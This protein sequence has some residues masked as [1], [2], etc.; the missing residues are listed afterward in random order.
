MSRKSPPKYRKRSSSLFAEY[1]KEAGFPDPR[2]ASPA[3]VRAV[4]RRTI[5]KEDPLTKRSL[6]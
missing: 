1:S 4:L 2:D 5:E 6:I 3:T